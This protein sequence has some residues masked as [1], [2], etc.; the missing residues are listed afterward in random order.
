[1]KIIKQTYLIKAPL[2]KVWQAFV[3]PKII[4]KWG[5]GPAKMNE[6][7]C[8]KFSLWGGD[9]HGT[10]TKVIKEKKLV[11][12]WYGG[13]W[14]T[15]SQVIFTFSREKNKTRVDL[16]HSNLPEDE[17]N[18]FDKG[19]KSDYLGPLKEFLEDK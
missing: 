6:D 4:D 16:V 8:F 13:D 1:M 10:N 15:P 3:D 17:V 14:V 2:E 19:W 7:E 12:D 9:I 5:A 11:Q 18:E